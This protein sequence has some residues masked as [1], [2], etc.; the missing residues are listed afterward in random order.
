[1][2]KVTVVTGGLGFIG[3]HLC[4]SYLEEGHR[5]I[6]VDN[7]LTGN[8]QNVEPYRKNSNFEWLEVDI[9]KGIQIRITFLS[10]ETIFLTSSKIKTVQ[11]WL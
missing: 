8:V 4:G 9:T 1:M 10:L 5:V 2:E 7:R 3:S 6:C 11:F